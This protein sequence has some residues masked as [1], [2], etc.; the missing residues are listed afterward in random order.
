MSLGNK[1]E[2]A[3]EN[4]RKRAD[5]KRTVALSDCL[6]LMYDAHLDETSTETKAYLGNA[7]S[8]AIVAAA[9]KLLE[10]S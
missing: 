2:A 6:D 7:F 4:A 3:I 1:V 10:T 8:P 5:A 9:R